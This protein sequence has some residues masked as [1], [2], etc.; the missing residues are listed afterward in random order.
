LSTIELVVDSGKLIVESGGL[1]SVN[2][3]LQVGDIAR[4]FIII[5]VLDFDFIEVRHCSGER[6]S[7]KE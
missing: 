5:L 3:E 2:V 4:F 7:S 6:S 1:Q